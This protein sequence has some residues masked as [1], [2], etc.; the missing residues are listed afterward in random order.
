[1]ALSAKYKNKNY[2]VYAA[3]GDG[4]SEEGQVWEAAM[5]AAHYKLDNLCAFLDLNGLQIDG[6]TA[7]VM[8]SAPADEKFKAFGWNV[9]VIDGHSFEDIENALNNAKETKGKPTVIV[10]KTVKGKGVSYMENQASWHGSAPNAEQYNT[11]I[12][13][14]DAVIAGLEE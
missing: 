3:I 2:R 4:E 11:A 1:M 5:F 9:L 8:S 12:S 10:C 13:E 7:D 6:N 14:L